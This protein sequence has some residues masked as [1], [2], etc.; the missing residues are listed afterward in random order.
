MCEPTGRPAE[1]IDA[2]RALSG[3]LHFSLLSTHSHCVPR[4]PTGS[5]P[6]ATSCSG[7]LAKGGPTLCEKQRRKEWAT[8]ESYRT[9]WDG[10]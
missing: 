10:R 2:D 1:V 5:G 4:A 3:A 9:I 6:L 7:W 8:Q